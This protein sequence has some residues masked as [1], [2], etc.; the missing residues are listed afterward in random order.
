MPTPRA[1]TVRG[2]IGPLLAIASSSEPRSMYSVTRYGCPVSARPAVYTVTTFGWPDSRA[3]VLASLRNAR[4]VASSSSTPWRSTL[5][6]T[7]RSSDCWRARY[8]CAAPPAPSGRTI[9]KPGSRGAVLF[10]RSTAAPHSGQNAAPAGT[11]V[12]QFPHRSAVASASSGMPCFVPRASKLRTC[13]TK[14]I[15]LRVPVECD[16]ESTEIGY[17]TTGGS[18]ADLRGFRTG[19]HVHHRSSHKGLEVGWMQAHDRSRDARR[20]WTEGRSCASR[21]W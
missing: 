8:T 21:Y 15:E 12:W 10:D 13:R 18:R 16:S 17:A 5:T 11:G 2:S 7:T 20:A 19:P 1:A 3:T 9:S 6:A 14:R 4:H